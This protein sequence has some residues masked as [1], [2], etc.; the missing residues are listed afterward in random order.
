M[1]ESKAEQQWQAE[2]AADAAECT[3]ALNPVVGITAKDLAA[4]ARTTA[5]QGIKQ[6]LILGKHLAG[7]GRKLVDAL[8]GEASY[9]AGRK[10]RRFQDPAWQESRIYNGLLQAYLALDDSLDEWVEDVDFDPVDRLRAG[11]AKLSQRN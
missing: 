4:A 5:L 1:S 2:V 8:S 3:L 10:D 7:F 9:E 6:P 11:I